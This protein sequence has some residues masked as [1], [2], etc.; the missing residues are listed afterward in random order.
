MNTGANHH[1]RARRGRRPSKEMPTLIPPGATQI[2]DVEWEWGAPTGRLIPVNG[3]PITV[4]QGYFHDH[5]PRKGGY[6]VRQED[7]YETFIPRVTV[8][9]ARAG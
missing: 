3:A 9:R 2:R 4:E 7:G 6:Y 8:E 5:M 1:Y